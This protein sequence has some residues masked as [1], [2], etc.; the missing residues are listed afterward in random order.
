MDLFKF[1]EEEALRQGVDPG[2]VTAV[3]RAESGGNAKAVSPKGARGPMQLMPGT[4]KDL[5]VDIDNPMQNI[6]GGIAYLKRQLDNFGS[7]ELALAAYNAGPENVKRHGNAVPPFAETQAYVQKVLGRAPAQAGGNNQSAA[8]KAV[9]P[10]GRSAYDEVAERYRIGGASAQ[11]TAGNAGEDP[12][13]ALESK[14]RIP[15]SEAQ[16]DG[17]ASNAGQSQDPTGQLPQANGPGN[18]L[19]QRLWQGLTDPARGAIQLLARG[20]EKLGIVP[21]AMRESFE[22]TFADDNAAYEQNKSADQA[23][24][25]LARLG[26]S[27]AFP[28]GGV[29]AATART[30]PAFLAA[31]A[32]AGAVSGATSEVR[33]GQTDNF[34]REKLAQI[35]MGSLV[36]AAGGAVA[37]GAD[38]VL[39][40]ASGQLNQTGQQALGA[41]ERLGVPVL[42]GQA[43]GS[44]GLQ[45]LESTLSRLP[46]SAG[47]MANVEQKAAG[48]MDRAALQSIGKVGDEVTDVALA[49]A[50]RD[51]SSAFT[52]LSKNTGARLDQQFID[53]VADIGNTNALMGASLRSSKVDSLV[54]DALNLAASGKNV[55]LK[56][57]WYQKFRSRIGDA[58]SDAYKSGNSDLGAALKGLRN[59]LDTSARN[60]LTPQEQQLWDRVRSQWSNLRVLERGKVTDKGDV[61][62]ARLQTALEQQF[63]IAAKE[64]K[65]SGPLADVARLRQFFGPQAQSRVVD[66]MLLRSAPMALGAGA[67]GA[68]G[69]GTGDWK[70]GMAIGAGMSM[71]PWAVAKAYTNPLT[72]RALRDGLVNMPPQFASRL[73]ATAGLLPY[74]HMLQQQKGN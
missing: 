24:L 17:Q 54:E 4:A 44:K 65:L 3:M 74:Q 60:G 37:R 19:S 23:G 45:Q 18:S 22:R 40:R 67:G 6:Q 9:Q 35:G 15:T 11:T 66:N 21:P 38:K 43:T 28:V 10:A 46:G 25:D 58:A 12:W 64:G 31:G 57:E 13:Q 72:Q 36:G 70:T 48:A 63:P 27:L 30:L 51:L 16:A 52:N 8:A 14:Y 71:A 73:G 5:G 62:P 47:V 29:G 59:A 20:G 26:G 53:T 68:Y 2:L 34:W 56:G 32:R 39:G 69:Y 55:T 42:A 61:N 49:S 50:R 7:P 1:A 33:P 41:A